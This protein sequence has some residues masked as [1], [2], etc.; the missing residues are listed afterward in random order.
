MVGDEA[1]DP[2]IK[3]PGLLPPLLETNL[4]S[5]S[6]CARNW[7]NQKQQTKKSKNLPF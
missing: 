5:K 3:R 2:W 4:L 1:H 7:K 6:A